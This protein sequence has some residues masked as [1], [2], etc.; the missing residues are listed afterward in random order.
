MLRNAFGSLA[1]PNHA[2]NAK[3]AIGKSLHCFLQEVNTALKCMDVH[4]VLPRQG[5]S[6]D[7][8][9]VII[10]IACMNHHRKMKILGAAWDLSACYWT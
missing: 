4:L 7:V 9:G 3:Y 10:G 5:I 1:A 8:H 6:Q 2:T